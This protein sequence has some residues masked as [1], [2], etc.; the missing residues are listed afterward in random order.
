MNLLR[1]VGAAMPCLACKAHFKEWATRNPIER[2]TGSYALREDARR[3]LWALHKEV[4]G[5]AGSPEVEELPA[6]YGS[7]RLAQD[8]NEDYKA[9]CASFQL[10]VQQ[11]SLA[12]EAFMTFKTRVVALRAITG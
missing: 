2:F 6:L 5:A 9:V 11:R 8:L 10:A 3:W 12:P 1:A 4:R 7:S